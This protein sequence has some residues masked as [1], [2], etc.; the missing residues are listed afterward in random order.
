M[1]ISEI[2]KDLKAQIIF[3]KTYKG[4]IVNDRAVNV[5][6]TSLNDTKN[7]D[8]KAQKCLNCGIM[9]SSILV[10]TD[11][12]NCGARYFTEEIKEEELIK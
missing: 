6:E 7:I 11:C 12:P 4:R 5:I 3:R 8:V 10:L 9:L 1:K 2:I